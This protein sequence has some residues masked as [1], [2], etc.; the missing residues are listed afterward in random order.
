MRHSSTLCIQLVL[1]VLIIIV[2]DVGFC[3]GDHLGHDAGCTDVERKALLRFRHGLTDPSGRLSSWVGKD[4]CKWRGVICNNRTG[5]VD[6][7]KLRN[8]YSD[9]DSVGDEAAMHALSGEINPSLLALKDLSSLDLSMN[10]FGGSKIP[11]FIGS[12]EKLRYL[13]LSGASF[14]GDIPPSLGNLSRLNYLDLSDNNYVQ[15][16]GNDF[17]WLSGLSSL[18]Y[19]DLEGWDLT[20]ATPNWLQTINML[21]S[22]LELRFPGCSLSS[23]SYN[24]P[25]LNLT[26]LFVLDLSNNRFSSRLPNW[27]FDLKSLV[28]LDLNSNNFHG[29]LPCSFSTFTSLEKLDL[30]ENN[31]GGSLSINFKKMCN[32][33]TLMLSG[34]NFIGEITEL[35]NSLSGCSKSRLEMLDLGY[36]HLRGILPHSV[37]SLKSLKCLKLSNNFFRGS[38]PK[39]I[40]NLTSIEEIH[41]SNNQMSGVIP[42]GLGQLSK[43]VVFDVSENTWEGVI[44]EAHLVNLSSLKELLIA[45]KQFPNTSL[46]FN[47]SSDWFPLFKLRNLEIRS[48][49]L[50][51]EFPSW[52]KNQ[53]ELTILILS[54]VEISGTIPDW[55]LQLDL[56]LE[57]LD[58]SYNQLNGR[59]PNS[60]RFSQF[61]IVDLSSN[62][63]DGP[64]PLWSSNVT[65]LNLRD[66][67]FSDPIPRDIGEVMPFL[68][69]LDFS[70]NPLGGSIPLSIGNLTSLT[71]LVISD[72][73]LSG[74]IP[75]FWDKLP[76]IDILDMS[77]NCLHGTI[78][79]SI[80]SLNYLGLL[81]LSNN[82]LSGQLPPSL[83][84]FRDL[85]ILDL[86]DNRLSGKLPTWIGE[87]MTSLFILR[88]RSNFFSGNIP[89]QFCRLSNLHIL[90]LSDNNMSGQI[91]HCFG[92][93]SGMESALSKADTERYLGLISEGRV[94]QYSS[95]IYLVRMKV[96]AKGS[97]LE[98][99][100][101]LYL[102]KSLDL[103]NNNLSG[104]IPKEL[105]SLVNL[106]TL[107]L[108]MNHLTGNLP[109]QIGKL[110]RL[111]TLDLSRNQLSGPIPRGMSSLTFLNHL[112]LSY[113]NLSGEIPTTNQFQTLNDPSIYRGNADLCGN[114]LPDN[115]HGNYIPGEEDREEKESGEE[116]DMFEKLGF[117]VS[118]V[119]GFAVG[120]WAVCGSLIVKESWRDA[121][122]GFFDKV[123]YHL[124]SFCRRTFLHV[125]EKRP[126]D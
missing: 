9:T 97:V 88:L 39:S 37:G 64:L 8:P 32:L 103:S 69:D 108:S 100:S 112:N 99:S 55:F 49:R 85:G 36:N 90:D 125:H 79:S 6:K 17:Q 68:M 70:R 65:M 62:R 53:N 34:N 92:N 89:S 28:H 18:K 114:P 45:N 123:Q 15:S 50:G 33:R 110:E 81:I 82:N 52:L 96:V 5:H 63:F 59:V 13:N 67:L 104:E 14:G 84:N 86:S 106:G 24:L 72:N 73:Q 74:E 78:P 21:P 16:N 40:Q 54:N 102:V 42:E 57:Q 121:Y 116:D 77:S 93:L 94:I 22:L 58:F 31:F 105:T 48:C 115:C 47:I 25:F 56:Q 30:S 117:F 76:L 124:L 111:E 66:N 44:T 109:S 38:I 26:S 4:C 91:P 83:E 98:Y 113:N 1:V 20:K 101:T 35:I 29:A 118:V 61:S 80:G 27:L 7:L 19:L 11:S 87:K 46:V 119:V 107:N 60:L 71:T 120:F 95:S 12:L 43:L 10:D 75:D 122:F 3:R 51:P 23:L 126:W 41:L 2:W